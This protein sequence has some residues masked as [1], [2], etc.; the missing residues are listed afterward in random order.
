MVEYFPE[1]KSSGGRVKVELDVS[2]QAAKADLKNEKGVD[3]SK[4]VKGVD[5]GSSKSNVDKIDADKLV[6]VP[7]D[8]SKLSDV[9]KNDVIKKNVYN[10]KTK[11]I[12]NKIPDITNLATN[13]TLNAEIKELLLLK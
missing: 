12:E 11:N 2:N 8:L 7:F 13:T 4:L 10:A 6:P 5:L 1:P 9:A 3:K